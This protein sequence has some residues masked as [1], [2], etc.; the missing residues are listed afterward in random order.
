[1]MVSCDDG[2]LPLLAAS[3]RWCSP[4]VGRTVRAPLSIFRPRR[5][6]F[7][8]CWLLCAGLS[9]DLLASMVHRV[10]TRAY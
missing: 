6:L 3:Q 4:A 10:L 9:V 7:D 5:A 2:K 8:L 1:M